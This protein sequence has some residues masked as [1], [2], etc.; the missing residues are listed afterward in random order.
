MTFMIYIWQ[1]VLN[2]R[3]ALRVT[4]A[5]QSE[6]LPISDYLSYFLKHSFNG[7]LSAI[8]AHLTIFF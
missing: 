7:T 6:A 2:P 4:I 1:N 5:G 3:W 8:F